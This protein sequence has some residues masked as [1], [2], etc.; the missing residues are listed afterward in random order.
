[1]NHLQ[2]DPNITIQN[3]VVVFSSIDYYENLLER[4]SESDRNAIVSE[5][6]TSYYSLQDYLDNYVRDQLLYQSPYTPDDRLDNDFLENILN[7]QGVVQIG[8]HWYKVDVPNEKVLALSTQHAD[9]FNDLLQGNITNTHLL[10]FNTTEEV[11]L[12]MQ[13]EEQ[14][15]LDSSGQAERLICREEFAGRKTDKGYDY[16]NNNQHRLDCKVVYQKAGIY[17]S[18]QGKA[19]H[20]TRNSNNKWRHNPSDVVDI[21]YTSFHRPRCRDGDINRGTRSQG[22]GTVSFRP[23][24]SSRALTTYDYSATFFVNSGPV[25]SRLYRI[26]YP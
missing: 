20:Q 24:E 17:F 19:H 11:L 22:G 5:L 10:V 25:Y 9:G 4:S 12:I 8:N 18:L 16:S 3:G 6:S 26:T 15:G 13:G 7:P 21:N 1:M 2:S 23:Y 14:K